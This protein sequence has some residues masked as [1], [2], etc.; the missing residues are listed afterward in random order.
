MFASPDPAHKS[1]VASHDSSVTSSEHGSA[2]ADPIQLHTTVCSSLQP[3][4][5]STPSTLLGAK[6]ITDSHGD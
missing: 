1:T 6:D 4:A 3:M 5:P 2:S